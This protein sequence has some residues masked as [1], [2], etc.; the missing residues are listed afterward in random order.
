MG[1]MIRKPDANPVVLGLANLVFGSLGYFLMG[2]SQKGVVALVITIVSMW[3]CG[4]GVVPALVFAYDGYLLAQKLAAG[5]S[6]GER[7]NALP[8]LDNL[9]GFN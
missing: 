9:P 3:C 6:I 2:Q 8:F 5:E 1:E 4:L 7:E